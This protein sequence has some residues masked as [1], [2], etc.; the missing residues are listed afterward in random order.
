MKKLVPVLV[1]LIA[2]AGILYAFKAHAAGQAQAPAKVPPPPGVQ[3]AQTLSM[4]TGV[5]MEVD[6]GRCI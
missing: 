6:G 1:V 4:I 5:A 2:V 3:I